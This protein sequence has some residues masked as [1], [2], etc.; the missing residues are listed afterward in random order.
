MIKNKHLFTHL[1]D[2]ASSKVQFG[3]NNPIDIVRKG[4]IAFKSNYEKIMHMHDTLY[5]PILKH[6]ILSIGHMYLKDYMLVF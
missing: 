3:D 1:E 5:I 4:T 6:N 2:N